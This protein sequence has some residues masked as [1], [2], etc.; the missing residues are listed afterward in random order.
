MWVDLKL[1]EFELGS[2]DREKGHQKR[3]NATQMAK[4]P[5][6]PTLTF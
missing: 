1:A 5:F 6:W 3:Q 2:I 4:T